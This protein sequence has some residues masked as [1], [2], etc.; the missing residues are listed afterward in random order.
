M[1]AS[2]LVKWG[3]ALEF[4][5]QRAGLSLNQLAER[6]GVSKGTLSRCESGTDAQLETLLKLMR[7]LPCLP[8]HALLDDGT[9]RAPAA[10]PAAWSTLKGHHGFVA[11]YVRRTIVVSAD[12]LREFLVLSG[13][14]RAVNAGLD[15]QATRMALM[16]AACI[17]DPETL[18]GLVYESDGP[19]GS[20]VLSDPRGLRHEFRFSQRVLTY[21][22]RGSV[23][24]EFA[25]VQEGR[26]P[27]ELFGVLVEYPIEQLQL[28]AVF[29]D[30]AELSD[31]R[32][33]AWPATVPPS[34]W[35]D[36]ISLR[37][38]PE[39][40]GWSKSRGRVTASVAS[41]PTG[42]FVA[43]AWSASGTGEGSPEYITLPRGADRRKQRELG[44]IVR[45]ARSDEP[46][47]TVATRAG[48]SHVTL[49]AVERGERAR[50]STL[51]GI[52]SALPELSPQDL[53]R[54]QQADGQLEL[55]DLHD[56]HRRLFGFE[57]DEVQ[58]KVRIRSDGTALTTIGTLGMRSLRGDPR[59][60]LRVR[61]GLQRTVVQET[62]AELR[63]MRLPTGAREF[64]RVRRRGRVHDFTFPHGWARKGFTHVRRY[65][66]NRFHALTAKEARQRHGTDD[67]FVEGVSL[68]VL[69]P[70]RRLVVQIRFPRG[71][72]PSEPRSHVTSRALMHDPD[73][74][75]LSPLARCVRLEE[76][77]GS[78]LVLR[79]EVAYPVVGFKY[80]I[81]W[82]LP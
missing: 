16:R 46:L 26:P 17:A 24:A 63:D 59:K 37:L 7:S 36:E 15:S 57:A 53:L 70:V 23:P 74:P 18:R 52:L 9:A 5:R 75:P 62:P 19:T 48:V 38:W 10:Q 30:G 40:V 79:V 65:R 47:R 8:P 12:G 78:I 3:A 29:P 42:I 6:S 76:V 50:R 4:A 11:R 13:G 25:E 67:V 80:G 61:L 28:E 54:G 2:R 68:P 33:Y 58:K 64:V 69:F 55:T 45:E 60:D 41:P 73:L 82:S 22:C 44:E 81:D 32:F 27:V 20:Q 77:V 39:G 66:R 1:R 51:M 56:F 49:G 34:P 31:V 71:Y 21:Q 43:L 35:S 14:L 72:R